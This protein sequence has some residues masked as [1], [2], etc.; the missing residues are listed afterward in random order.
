MRPSP[1]GTTHLG[2]A[3]TALLAW[4]SVRRQGGAYVMRMEDLDR[5]RVVRGSAEGILEDLRWL[6][7]DWD[8][9]PDI[10]GPYG[11]TRKASASIDTK[12]R[13]KGF[14]PKDGSTRASAAARTS[15]PP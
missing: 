6:G 12:P 14:A 1:T 15:T 10:G 4:L 7:L 8:E 11:R 5:A 3:S 13:S 9:G 2:N